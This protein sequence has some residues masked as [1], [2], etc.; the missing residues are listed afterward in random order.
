MIHGVHASG[1]RENPL[2]VVGFGGFNTHVFD[3]NEV[4]FPGRLSNCRTCHEEGTWR[5]PL[6]DSVLATTID[7]GLDILDPGDDLMITPM[8]SVCSS[9]HDTN[10]AKGHMEQ[11]GADF[12]ATAASIASGASTEACAICHGEGRT[13]DIDV[14]HDLD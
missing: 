2:Q 12:T 7:T 13:A 14:M 3:E 4:H 6:A 10:L 9:C 1:F 5:L 8:A 11:N